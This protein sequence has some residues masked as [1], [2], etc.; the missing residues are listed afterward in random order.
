MN[1]N[2]GAKKRRQ[3]I[4]VWTYEQARKAVPYLTSVMQTVREYRI[5]AKRHYR[6]ARQLAH[7]P[8]R[9]DRAALM[10]HQDSLHE[11]RRAND[12]FHEALNELHAMGVYCLDPVRGESLVPFA[13]GQQLAWF[14]FDMFDPDPLRFWRFHSDPLDK[15]RPI[16]ELGFGPRTTSVVA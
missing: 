9:P 5:E 14:V 11:G 10:A 1:R 12:R 15:R 8:G 4:P 3:T 6:K 7:A 2:K 16:G 13:H